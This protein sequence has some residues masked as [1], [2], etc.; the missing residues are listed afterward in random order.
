MPR[1]AAAIAQPRAVVCPA[2]S[3]AQATAV[4]GGR[5]VAVGTVK[6]VLATAGPS[7]AK[8]DL[9][10]AAVLPGFNDTHNHQNS[11]ISLMT[12]VDLTNIHSIADIQKAI[13]ARVKTAVKHEWIAGTRGWWEYE[14]VGS[15]CRIGTTST[16]WRPTIRWRSRDRAT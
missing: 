13:A 4:R 15:G 8:I 11:G 7:T 12:G 3:I 10:G 5:F 16:R 14:L 6:E 2:A 1:P 9:H